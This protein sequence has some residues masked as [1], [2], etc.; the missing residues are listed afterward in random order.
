MARPRPA[1]GSV[2]ATAGLVLLALMLGALQ[3][4]ASVALRDRAQPGSWV[5][6]LSRNDAR[7]FAG[8]AQGLP[9]PQTLLLVF[10][11]EAFKAR[12]YAG[13]AAEIGRMRPSPDTLALHAALARVR[14]NA[15]A[16]AVDDAAAGDYDALAADLGV[17]AAH[18]R[19]AR[20]LALQ[21]I[22]VARLTAAGTEPGALAQAQYVLG[23]FE[24]QCAYECRSASGPRRAHEAAAGRAYEAALALAPLDERYLLAAANQDLNL[25]A[26]AAAAATFER[27]RAADP[28]SADP[29][30]GFGDLALRRGDRAAARAFLARARA[31]DPHSA[32]VSSLAA[33]LAR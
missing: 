31:L 13:A 18:G 22:A 11:R 29:L 14:G 5:T 17:L 23:L 28:T 12:D 7:R 32:A 6:L 25:G 4:C 20:A 19:V 27:A 9:L 16:A 26:F 1:P 33:K 2:A 24:Q 30:A 21:R 10:A 8:F 3:V 15:D